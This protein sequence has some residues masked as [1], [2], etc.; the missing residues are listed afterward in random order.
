MFLRSSNR[1]KVPIVE[2]LEDSKNR[3]LIL[4]IEARNFIERKMIST[5]IFYNV[6]KMNINISKK[7][8]KQK[9]LEIENE[10]EGFIENDEE[11]SDEEEEES[12]GELKAIPGIISSNG[13]QH[14]PRLPIP[15]KHKWPLK[16]VKIP[17]LN[18]FF[19]KVLLE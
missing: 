1:I 3:F 15:K 4:M 11:E 14:P 18:Q 19:E 12:E 7:I 10:L 9:K 13:F 6:T 17:F 16:F 2:D 5:P 8:N